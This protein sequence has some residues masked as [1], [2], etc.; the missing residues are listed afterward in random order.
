MAW[1]KCP[2]GEERLT[3]PREA[4]PDDKL[5]RVT[6]HEGEFTFTSSFETPATDV[7][8]PDIGM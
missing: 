8:L 2:H 4:R 5:G 6:H 7:G 3:H 1:N